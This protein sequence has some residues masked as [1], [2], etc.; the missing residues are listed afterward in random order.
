MSNHFGIFQRGRL[1]AISVKAEH[2]TCFD[3]DL[4]KQWSIRR[5]PLRPVGHQELIVNSYSVFHCCQ[6][7]ESVPVAT[8]AFLSE[9]WPCVCRLRT[10]ARIEVQRYVHRTDVR[11]STCGCAAGH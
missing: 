11:S 8:V 3:A 10:L 1:D 2:G 4:N 5:A 9:S 6:L 7:Q